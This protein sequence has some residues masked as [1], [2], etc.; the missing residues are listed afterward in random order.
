M[1]S[2]NILVVSCFLLTVV[3]GC[4]ESVVDSV[5]P[6][7]VEPR[8][9]TEVEEKLAN[10]DG[11]FSYDVFR[12]TVLYDDKENVIISPLSISMALSMA[13][14]GAEG[15]T[16]NQMRETLHLDGVSRDEINQ[17]FLSLMAFLMNTDPSVSVKIAN[18]MWYRQGLP[19]KEEF[20]SDIKEFYE[21]EISPLDFSD[22]VSV[23]II[24]RWVEN[25]T[26]G[27]IDTILE[28]VPDE[29]VMYLINALYFN[30][31]WT[32]PFDPDETDIADFYLENG[33]KVDVQMMRQ[34]DKLATYFSEDVQMIE[35]PYGDSLYSMT[36][37]MPTDFDEPLDTFIEEKV[38]QENIEL[39]RS[40]LRVPIRDV[41]L[42]MPKFELEYEVGYNNIL[43]SM[44]ME[45]P[46][47]EGRA[48][49]SRIA[50]L[51]G[52]NLF[53]SDVK[54][55]T[56]FKVDEKGTEAA[57]VTSVGVGV[58]SMPPSVVLNR[59][60][61]FIIHERNSGVNLFMGKVKNP[62]E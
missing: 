22:P 57:A 32:Y 45:L 33:D 55:K 31:D 20:L 51:P 58:T 34:E 5:D 18:S 21:A 11:L 7:P 61:V 30:G 60:F 8:L 53:I 50:E 17:N 28:E 42:K 44:G 26:E 38:T 41:I 9:L 2:I 19:V 15:E 25:N 23:D 54:H 13:L 16:Y 47:D 6:D 36:V 62:V 56:F 37:L 43:K 1:K 4:N 39:W 48:D 14:H 29:M 27:L 46:F 52:Q 59:P 3:L 24:N 35:L 10:A 49:F 40:D 12:N